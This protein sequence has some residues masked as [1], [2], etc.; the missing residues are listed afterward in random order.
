VT[1]ESLLLALLF[2]AAATLYASVGHA[3]AS[4]YLA[5]MA[6]V[7]VAPEVMRPTALVLNLFVATIVV[8]RFAR[9]GHLPW[10]SLFPLVAGSIP[11]AFVGGSINLPGELYRPLVACVLLVGAWRLATAATPDDGFTPNG[12]PVVAGVVA[13]AAIG[14]L[15]GLTGTGGG[16]F[17]TPLLVLAAWT[18]TRDAA[19][20]SGAFIGLNSLSGLAGLATGGFTLPA[21]LPLWVVAV[22]AGGL[23]GS[24]LGTARFSVLNL[25]RALAVVLVLAAAKLVFLP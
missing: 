3:G 9:A 15:A 11:A 22:V 12:V 17:L 21:A 8:V 2:L 23:I 10:R 6:L 1:P 24:W 20:L 18:G 16:I 4:A 19:G 25:R 7:G 14:L 5:A 13:G